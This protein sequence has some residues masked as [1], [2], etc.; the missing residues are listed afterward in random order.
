[1]SYFGYQ[2]G[3]FL[4]WLLSF[5]FL[6][7]SKKLRLGLK[8]RRG[9]Q[10]RFKEAQKRWGTEGLETHPYWFHF[11]SA[12]ELEQAIPIAEAVKRRYPKAAVLFTF[13]SPSGE[14]GVRLETLR[15]EKANRPL[16]WDAADYLPLDLPWE[17]SKTL[18]ILTPKALILINRELWPNLVKMSHAR[19]IPIYLFS[20][21]FPNNKAKM[22][23]FWR[24]YLKH[25]KL[26]GTVGD[27][28]TELL[29]NL[30]PTLCVKS[31][32]DT[33]I[34]RVLERKELQKKPLPWGT[35]LTSN[36]LFIGA[37]LWKEDFQALQPVLRTIA[38]EFTD[39]RICLVPHEPDDSFIK[40]I[41]EWGHAEGISFRRFSHFLQTPDEVSPLIMDQV[42]LLA[43]LYRYSSLAFVGGSF[44]QKVHNVLEPAAY[45]N[46]IVVGPFIQN[47][48]EATEMNRLQLGLKSAKTSQE[49]SETILKR[50]SDVSFLKSEGEA[51]YKYLLD[52]R[53]ASEKYGEFL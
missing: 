48:F 13:F 23:E 47:S 39:W 20:A 15:R 11:A 27:S 44:K 37:S 7:F 24:P 4:F 42:G 28:S 17:V 21:F 52:R 30:E 53:G 8:G 49:T 5:A 29:L 34:E 45:S 2:V 16:P 41:K 40:T 46:A 9:L 43:E 10:M 19:N 36:K 12:G 51:A 50:I 26:I 18:D 3:Y 32:G 22:L 14:K 6:P 38:Q 35:F 1:M 31:M 33:R 25:L